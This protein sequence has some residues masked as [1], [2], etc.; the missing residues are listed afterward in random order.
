MVLHPRILVF[1]TLLDPNALRINFVHFGSSDIQHLSLSQ[2]LVESCS[3][4]DEA[5]PQTT[6]MAA[7]LPRHISLYL[8]QTLD[9]L[10]QTFS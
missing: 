10:H 8:S 7:D 2:V 9:P 5:G 4:P 3:S 1:P 6:M